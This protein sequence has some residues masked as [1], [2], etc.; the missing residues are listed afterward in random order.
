[1]SNGYGGG[2]SGSSTSTSISTSSSQRV[3]APQQSRVNTQGQVA[4]EGFH[5]MPD[6]SL[7]SDVEHAK[8]FSIKTI[9]GFGPV[10]VCGPQLARQPSLVYNVGVPGS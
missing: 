5:Y 4:P 7:M 8:L 9:K 1:M 10:L 3:A 6:G 2:S